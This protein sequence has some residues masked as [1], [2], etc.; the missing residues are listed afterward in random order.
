MSPLASNAD[1][2]S[3]RAR[4]EESLRDQHPATAPNLNVAD[5]Q[6]LL[7]ELQVHQIELEM[8][9]DEL[10]R[11]RDKVEQEMEKYSDLYDFAPVGYVTLDRQGVI[12]E[13]NLTCAG[14]L[15]IERA[16]LIKRRFG[17]CVS[18]AHLPQY[19]AF[20]KRVFESQ[21]RATCEVTLLKNGEFPIDV[22]IEGVAA[23]LGRECR[24]AVTD[25]TERK[26]AD[27]DRLVLSKLES[28]GIL[29]GGIAHDFNNL[30]TV[31]FLNLELGRMLAPAGEEWGQRLGE[32]KKA[33]LM[34]RDLTQQ[35]LTFAEGG[36]PVLKVIDLATTIRES[37]ALAL[38]GSR[39]QAELHIP[40]NLWTAEADAGQIRQ[41]LRNLILNAREA[42]PEGGVVTIQAENV[43]LRAHHV[44][45]LPDGRYVRMSIVDRGNGIPKDVLPKI[46]DPY[47]S[48]KQRGEQKGMGLGLTLCHTILQKHGGAIAVESA[49]GFETTFILYLPASGKV[50]EVA[51]TAAPVVKPRHGR[52]LIMDDEEGIR[53]SVGTALRH[54]GHDVETA[55]NGQRAL[56]VFARARDAK[57]PFD[58]VI[59]DLTVRGGMGGR[60]TMLEL[61]KVDPTVKGIVMSGYASDPVV[62][63]FARHGFQAALEKPFAISHLRDMLARVM[64]P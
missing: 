15:G 13:A 21:A 48:T 1:D 47:F 62:L 5:T 8:Q 16:Q 12:T 50:T 22:L 2:T 42:M 14:L 30:L 63:D 55:E 53:L 31:I 19:N 46:F 60:E 11:A 17:L 41:V 43:A 32:A 24:A 3:R 10:Q 52:V 61:L 56:D 29:A 58:A 45:V 57:R 23:A 59:L 9:N 37:A 44:P 64:G 51:S 49:V 36:A 39:V 26:R 28:T 35:L 25:I 54:L 7:H 38:S 40:D 27:V 20:L 4:A 18:T 33:I 34:A 6:H